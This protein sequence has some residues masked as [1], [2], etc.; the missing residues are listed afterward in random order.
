VGWLLASLIYCGLIFYASSRSTLPTPNLFS[1]QDKLIH[2]TAY[3]IM[4][5]LFWHAAMQRCH[6]HLLPW[7]VVAACACYGI[8]DEFHQSF[9]PGRDASVWDWLADISGATVASMLLFRYYSTR[10]C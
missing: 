7:L 4:A 6:I 10:I 1:G 5:T 8:S 2:A 3:A 9:V